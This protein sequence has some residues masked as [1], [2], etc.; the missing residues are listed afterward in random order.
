VE[1]YYAKN[2]E[3]TKLL[4]GCEIQLL[5]GFPPDVTRG[6]LLYPRSENPPEPSGSPCFKMFPPAVFIQQQLMT[7]KNVDTLYPNDQLLSV[8][9]S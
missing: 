8:V 2:R 1:G 7:A 6:G 9:R 4:A 3:Q 5:D